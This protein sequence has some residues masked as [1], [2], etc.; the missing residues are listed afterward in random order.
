MK[1]VKFILIATF[2]SFAMMSFSAIEAGLDKPDQQIAIE[3]AM[4][5][6]GL[7]NAMNFQISEDLISIEQPGFYFAKVRYHG[8]TFVIYGKLK[9][10]QKYFRERKWVRVKN[11]KENKGIQ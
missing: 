2:V 5:S 7:L 10:W 3:K 4:M 8:K 6:R 9:A 11:L 1:T